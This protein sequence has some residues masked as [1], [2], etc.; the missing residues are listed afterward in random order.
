MNASFLPRR[1]SLYL[2]T[3]W[4]LWP[5]FILDWIHGCIWFP[6]VS[7]QTIIL[8]IDQNLTNT[9]KLFVCWANNMD[10]HS[11]QGELCNFSITC[12]DLSTLMKGEKYKCLCW[13]YDYLKVPKINS[14]K[15]SKNELREPMSLFFSPLKSSWYPRF[16]SP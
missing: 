15:T 6:L 5:L 10:L 8:K 9:Q 1:T 7:S 11:P 13:A 16:V 14:N 4:P 12:R 3:T 2:F